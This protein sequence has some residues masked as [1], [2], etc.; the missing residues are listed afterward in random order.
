MNRFE[1]EHDEKQLQ[2]Q[3]SIDRLQDKLAFAISR[4]FNGSRLTVYGS[5]LSGLA[6]EGSHDVDVSIFI[7]ELDRLKKNFDRGTVSASEYEK[8][9]RRIIYQVRDSLEYCRSRSFADLFAITR[10]RVPVVKG[11]DV[12]AQNPYTHDGSL[13]FDL[14]FLNDIAVV[15]SSLLRE[16]SL[17]DNR[18]RI[19]MLSVKSFA[20]L[21]GIASAADGTLSSYSWLNMVVFYLQCIGFLPALQ[22][23]K[24]MQ[25][26][27]FEPDQNGNPWH[28]INGLDTFYLTKEMVTKRNIWERQIHV[29]D[30][31]TTRLLF[32]FFNF[33]SIVFPQQTVAASIRFG[34]PSLQKTS[35]SKTSK[36]WRLCVEDPFE[37]CS[38][39]C[40][41]DLGCHIKEDGQ[42]R[43]SEHLSRASRKLGAFMQEKMACDDTISTFLCQFLG[44]MPKSNGEGVKDSA[45]SVA[46]QARNHPRNA[47]RQ[48]R[49]R[50]NTGRHNNR[51]GKHTNNQRNQSHGRAPKEMKRGNEGH[52]TN[53]ARS[54][55]K[56]DGR[57]GKND[58]PVHVQKKNAQKKHQR[59]MQNKNNR[60]NSDANGSQPSHQSLQA[61]HPAANIQFVD[62][63]K[64]RLRQITEEKTRKE[65]LKQNKK[66]GNTAAVGGKHGS[67][68]KHQKGNSRKS[69]VSRTGNE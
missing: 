26:H 1:N 13:S 31:S 34:K 56:G 22:C 66:G 36:L 39:H 16:Y 61:D 69:D 6:L 21:N 33:Y 55:M 49:A 65:H 10:A 23:P 3:L 54:Q 25:E 42:K 15:N 44:P 18:V 9:A 29:N 37:T 8:K 57:P 32:G 7:P 41:H 27:D 12:H 59:Q 60:D 48:D 38:S 17:F 30:A 53:P 46:Q 64:E 67:G 5:V 62:K 4:R 14:C 47:P 68:D 43:I 52:G 45:S 28:S 20:K 35:L 50:T 63:Q 58:Q 2:L 40:P 24:M 11:T 51:N 19:L